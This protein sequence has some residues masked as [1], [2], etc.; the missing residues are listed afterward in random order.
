MVAHVCRFMP[1]YRYLDIANWLFGEPSGHDLTEISPK[2]GAGP[3]HV[4]SRLAYPATGSVTIEA[5]HLVRKST[6][7]L[8]ALRRKNPSASAPGKRAS[9]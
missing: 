1:Q 9:P 3:S 4:I 7:S 5:R 2:S 6:T 8:T